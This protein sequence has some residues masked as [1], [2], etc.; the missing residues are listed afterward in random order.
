MKILYVITKGNWGGAQKYVFDMATHLPRPE[1]EATVACGE[2][3]LLPKK[4]ANA[5]IRV[6]PLSE[7]GRDLRIIKDARV[8]SDLVKLFK[9]ERP[10][11]VHLNSSKIGSLGALAARLAGIPKIIFTVHGFAFNEDRPWWQKKLISFLSWLTIVFCTEVIFISNTERAQASEWPGIRNKARLIHNGIDAPDFVSKADARAQLASLLGRPETIFENKTVVGTIAELTKNK[12]LSF[13]LEAVA[14]TENIL[15][16]I[17]GQGELKEALETEIKDKH[18]ESRVLLAGFIPNASSLLKA[19]DIFLLPSLKEGVPYV[20]LE[21]GFAGVP[22]I[23]AN[24]GGVGEII[25]DGETGSLVVSGSSA[26]IEKALAHA[27]AQP[28]LYM[29]YAAKLHEHAVNHFTLSNAVDN[30]LALYR[31]S[32]I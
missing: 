29:A 14:H 8:F 31:D 23:A 20:L 30:T 5:G 18:L 7:L 1:F 4:L 6:I 12:G 26:S 28:D 25:S 27:L 3:E 11:I 22:V 19:F 16:I 13:A 2:G 9:K 32:A 24:V 10:D 21:A 17:I 15:Y